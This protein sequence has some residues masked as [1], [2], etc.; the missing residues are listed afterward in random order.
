MANEAGGGRIRTNPS[1]ISIEDP[2]VP[3]PQDKIGDLL[4]DIDDRGMGGGLL[5]PHAD[6]PEDG[7]QV[8][9][10]CVDGSA[11]TDE[12]A[13][14]V[15]A[16]RT[17]GGWRQGE[18]I[19]VVVSLSEVPSIEQ[20]KA[21]LGAQEE[22]TEGRWLRGGADVI[23]LTWTPLPTGEDRITSIAWAWAVRSGTLSTI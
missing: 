1:H 17:N 22:A 13:E 6:E 14:K 7:F 15:C 23:D 4:G 21:W 3:P 5:Q 19:I 12:L 10:I 9:V 20:R 16:L 2:G 18:R 11:V 8:V